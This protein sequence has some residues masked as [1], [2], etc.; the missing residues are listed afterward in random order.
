M[1]NKAAV[2][3]DQAPEQVDTTALVNRPCYR[4]YK[5]WT[6]VDSKKLAPGVYFHFSDRKTGDPRTLWVCNHLEAAL[7]THERET[8]DFSI[9]LRF[10]TRAGIKELFIDQGMISGKGGILCQQLADRKS[11]V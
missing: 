10:K 7:S 2:Q 6:E 11:V 1:A 3:K 5:Q 9:K 8:G 4:L